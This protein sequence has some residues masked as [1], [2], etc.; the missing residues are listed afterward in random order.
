M[1]IAGCRDRPAR[2]D[3]F[4][5]IVR[6]DI[7]GHADRNAA[8]AIDQD[9]RKPCRQDLG[10]PLGFVVIRLELDGVLVE[11]VEQRVG[12]AGEPRLGVPVGRRGVAVHRAEIALAV[13]QRQ[14]HRE[15]P[16]RAAIAS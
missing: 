8:A 7:G 11:V 12:D 13:D 10:L 1:V 14:A 9:V 4:A 5:E 2:V 6:W 3:D 15:I 16:P